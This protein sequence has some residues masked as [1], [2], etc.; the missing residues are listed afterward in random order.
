MRE[1][2]SGWTFER[3]ANLTDEQI[4][5]LFAP[6]PMQERERMRTDPANQHSYREVFERIWR[7]RGATDEEMRARWARENPG[8]AW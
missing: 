7:R 4:T 3:I 2:F 8:E 1:P 6:D 5:V